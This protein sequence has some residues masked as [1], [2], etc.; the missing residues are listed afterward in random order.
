MNSNFSHVK[1]MTV[2]SLLIAIMLIMSYTPLGYLNVGPLAI[3]FNIIPVA[4]AGIALGPV[5]GAIIGGT[6]GITSFLQCIG[7]GGASAFGAALFAISPISTFVVCFVTRLL[8]GILVG[9]IFDGLRN[10]TNIQ[11]SMFAAGFFSA[12]LNTL[13]FMTALMAC[14]GNTEMIQGLRGEKSLIPFMI[15]FVGINAVVE[16]LTAT[17]IVGAIGFAMYKSNLIEKR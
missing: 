9:L 2:L 13:F 5:G 3:T 17:I 14:F 4:I 7:V 10:K 15:S 11:T 6:F 12:F 16:I 8:V 1:K